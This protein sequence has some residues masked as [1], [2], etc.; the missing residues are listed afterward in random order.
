MRREGAARGTIVLGAA[1]VVVGLSNYAFTLALAHLLTPDAFGVATVVQSFL[2]FAAW[3]IGA[4][5]PWTAARRLSVLNRTQEQAPILRDALLGNLALATVLAVLLLA[6][7]AAGVLKLKSEPA[8]PVVIGAVACATLGITAAAK[9]ALQGLFSLAIVAAANFLEVGVKLAVGVS[10]AAAGWGATGAALGILSGTVASTV[11]VLGVLQ[12]RRLLSGRWSGWRLALAFYRET[13]P[14]FSAMA[15][16]AVLASLDVFAIKVL[17]PVNASNSNAAVY[18]VAVTL[19]R[20]PYFLGTAVTA[21]VFPYL[22]R[23]QEETAIA[24]LYLR[25]ALFYL[26]TVLTPVGLTFVLAPASTVF[27]FF[28]ARYAAAAPVLQVLSIGGVAIAGASVLMGAYQAMGL[29]GVAAK[30]AAG[31]IVVEVVLLGIVFPICLANGTEA[32]L[33]G[34][35]AVFDAVAMALVFSLLLVARRR[36]FRWHPR[37]RGGVGLVLSAAAF[38]GLLELLP[39]EGRGQLVMAVSVAGLVYCILLVALRVLSRGDIAAFL[40]GVGLERRPFGT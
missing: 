5:L 23:H 9:G 8:A 17:S 26:V 1:F 12:R 28:P 16:M 21:A 22:A 34:T 4:G 38:A 19:A 30:I 35:A 37:P 36:F 25:K 7:L 3:M 33:T 14:M 24:S 6:C 15:G 2:L 11:L 13:L 10:L 20:V 39:H 40:H 18:Q 29:A 27:A 32:L 31:A